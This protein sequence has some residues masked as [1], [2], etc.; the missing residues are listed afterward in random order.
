MCEVL[1]KHCHFVDFRVNF[2]Q[3]AMNANKAQTFLSTYINITV[4][5]CVKC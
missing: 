2:L 3:Q 5:L 4:E 1:K